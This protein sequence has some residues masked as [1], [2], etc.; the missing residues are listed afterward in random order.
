MRSPRLTSKHSGAAHVT[1]S[2]IIEASYEDSVRGDERESGS[3]EIGAFGNGKAHV[4]IGE[5]SLQGLSCR[6]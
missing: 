4:L 3:I 6:R 5:A 1:Y 2:G